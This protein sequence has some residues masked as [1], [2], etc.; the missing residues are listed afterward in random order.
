V[1]GDTSFDNFLITYHRFIMP[2]LNYMVTLLNWLWSDSS[3]LCCLHNR[4]SSHK[5]VPWKSNPLFHVYYKL[6]NIFFLFQCQHSPFRVVLFY[7]ILF[8]RSVVAPNK[9]SWQMAF[10]RT[11]FWSGDFGRWYIYRRLL[12]LWLTSDKVGRLTS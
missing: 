1:W 12:D 11:S 2:V 8:V 3:W 10:L 6:Y 7:F 9:F 4:Q 5:F